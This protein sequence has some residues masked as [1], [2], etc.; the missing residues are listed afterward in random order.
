MFPSFLQLRK[1]KKASIDPTAEDDNA[2]PLVLAVASSPR[3]SRKRL[4]SNTVVTVPNN[5][6]I[7]KDDNLLGTH[8]LETISLRFSIIFQ[9]DFLL[10]VYASTPPIYEHE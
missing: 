10:F 7:N 8:F 3:V 6:D 1:G 2:S 4:G 5:N 9:S